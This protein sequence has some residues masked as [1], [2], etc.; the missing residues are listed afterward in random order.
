MKQPQ[1]VSFD[2]E[3]KA[4]RYNGCLLDE[5]IKSSSN[6]RV[7]RCKILHSDSYSYITERK[8][9]V[10][11]TFLANVQMMRTGNECTITTHYVKME[12]KPP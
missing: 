7:G 4:D 1:G 6:A 3:H 8:E 5:N 9:K 12:I 2:I 10:Q 11:C